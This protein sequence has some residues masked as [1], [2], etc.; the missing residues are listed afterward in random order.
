MSAKYL[1]WAVALD[2][3]LFHLEGS[4]QKRPDVCLFLDDDTCSCRFQADIL[5]VQATPPQ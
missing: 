2:Q 4:H 5:S 1:L 3:L